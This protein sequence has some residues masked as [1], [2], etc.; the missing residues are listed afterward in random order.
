MSVEH[1]LTVL[2]NTSQQHR[3]QPSIIEASQEL[4]Y[5]DEAMTR[6]RRMHIVVGQQKE[7]I[8]LVSGDK[9]GTLRV[10]SEEGDE[11]EFTDNETE[12]LEAQIGKILLDKTRVAAD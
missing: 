9:P 7:W 12:P 11:L 6:I 10:I 2:R 1:A 5:E 4:S 8:S 3:H